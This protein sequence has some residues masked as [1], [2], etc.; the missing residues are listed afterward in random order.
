MEA[1]QT[2]PYFQDNRFKVCDFCGNEYQQDLDFVHECPDGEIPPYLNRIHVQVGG[3]Q[4]QSEV[5]YEYNKT[6]NC[7]KTVL[8]FYGVKTYKDYFKIVNCNKLWCPCCGGKNGS[9]HQSRL[10]KVLKIVEKMGGVDNIMIRQVILTVPEDIRDFFRSKKKLNA[11]VAASNRWF[12]K[13]YP[14]A[15]ALVNVH[16]FGDSRK[17]VFNPHINIQ[18]IEKF[19]NQKGVESA[20]R[21]QEFKKTWLNQLKHMIEKEIQVI[22]AYYTFRLGSKVLHSLKY[23]TKPPSI[24]HYENLTD[25][26]RE[27]YFLELK[28]FRYFRLFGKIEK[29]IKDG[30]IKEEIEDLEGE[31]QERLIFVRILSRME[32]RL[33]FREGFD[34]DLVY[35]GFYRTRERDV[36]LH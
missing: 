27:F 9:I 20:N 15:V 1:V 19:E 26:D 21:L 18:V 13:F 17:S 34:I 28:G 10:M 32:F 3:V 11:L 16:I 23:M 22:N 25:A 5:E 14:G 35:N 8:Q 33:S 4:S 29:G 7:G 6:S 2:Q 36:K 12:H 24:F 31:V 30:C